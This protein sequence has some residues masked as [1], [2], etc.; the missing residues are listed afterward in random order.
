MYSFKLLTT[1]QSNKTN[2]NSIKSLFTFIEKEKSNWE[3][4]NVFLH[5]SKIDLRIDL[6]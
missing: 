6:Q 4:S 3:V 1:E 2:F 5:L